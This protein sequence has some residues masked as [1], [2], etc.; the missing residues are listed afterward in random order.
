M[1]DKLNKKQNIIANRNFQKDF[2][3]ISTIHDYSTKSNDHKVVV[4]CM[5]NYKTRPYRRIKPHILE[6]KKITRARATNINKSISINGY[7]AWA[8]E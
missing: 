2:K 4:L 1:G 5:R 6:N 8:F 3:I 7:T